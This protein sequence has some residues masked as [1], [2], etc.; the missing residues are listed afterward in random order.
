MLNSE[1][2]CGQWW[3]LHLEFVGLA[4]GLKSYVYGTHVC[5][6]SPIHTRKIMGA[7]CAVSSLGT[8]RLYCEPSTQS[9]SK[10][11]SACE[12]HWNGNRVRKGGAREQTHGSQRLKNLRG[13]NV[14][15]NC[16][17]FQCVPLHCGSNQG[18]SL[19][20]APQE[21]SSSDVL[22]FAPAP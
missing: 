7:D 1:D 9:K 3:G 11:K 21:N 6:K 13:G 8:D 17:M 5:N 10:S 14:G 18:L 2:W 19:Y 12:W 4:L 20:S 16:K 15:T 22:T